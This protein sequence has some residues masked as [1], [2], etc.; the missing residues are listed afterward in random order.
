MV[1]KNISVIIQAR[2]NSSRFPKKILSKI[3]NNTLLEIL[4]KRILKSKKIDDIIIA[5]T[6]KKEDDK[7]VEICKNYNVK[8]FRGSEKNVFDRYYQAAKKF[9]I[10]NIIRLTS[11]CPL[12][13]P[14]IL[15]KFIEKFFS[16]GFDYL[17]NTI[18]PTF[19]DGMDIEIF[20]YKIMKE[21]ILKKISN[22]EK[23]HV[24]FGFHNKKKI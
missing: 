6:R 14:R 13:D 20:K 11:D 2:V 18:N 7:I 21:K 1:K 15:N 3:Q 10:K 22:H 16:G 8:I 9:K 19:P 4:I 23:E 17:S 12:I 5:C 24:T